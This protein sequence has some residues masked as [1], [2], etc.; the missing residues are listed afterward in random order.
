MPKKLSMHTDAARRK[1]CRETSDIMIDVAGGD[2]TVVVVDRGGRLPKK[3]SRLM[4][5]LAVLLRDLRVVVVAMELIDV[6]DEGMNADKAAVDIKVAR[7]MKR[8]IDDLHGESMIQGPRP[9]PNCSDSIKTW[10]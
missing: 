1:S 10:D 7:I 8:P 2:G 3:E 9:R 5:G 6:G 4:L